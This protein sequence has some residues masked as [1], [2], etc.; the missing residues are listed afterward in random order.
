VKKKEMFNEGM[1]KKWGAINEF[2]STLKGVNPFAQRAPT[3]I[4]KQVRR[5][6]DQPLVSYPQ[7]PPG[8]LN[9]NLDPWILR[10]PEAQQQILPP[11]KYTFREESSMAEYVRM[12]DK[13]KKPVT[14]RKTK[15]EPE[16]VIVS[17]RAF[18]FS[19]D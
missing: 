13:M 3:P 9:P 5:T 7:A 14:S 4:E 16:T 6:W 19:Q 12:L 8:P 15:P 1:N 11:T 18:D 10:G 2:R 17:D